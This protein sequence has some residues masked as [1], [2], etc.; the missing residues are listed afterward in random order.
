MKNKYS[1][2]KKHIKNLIQFMGKNLNITPYPKIILN[3]S[4]QNEYHLLNKTAFYNPNDN[5][6]TVYIYNRW[7]KDVLRSIAHELIHHY[8]NLENRLKSDDYQGEEIIN[9]N[10]LLKLEEEAYL[11][12]NIL[13]RKW[14]EK[15]NNY[16]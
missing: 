15:I 7:L 14:T 11:K 6:I 12:G 10:K 2:Y 3:N 16:I 9:D 4:K 8:Q 1:L 13:F 5:T